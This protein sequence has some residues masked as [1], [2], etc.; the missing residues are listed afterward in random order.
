MADAIHSINSSLDGDDSSALLEQLTN[1]YGGLDNI[2]EHEALQYLK[3][4]RATKAAKVE[5]GI[6]KS[7][8]MKCFYDCFMVAFGRS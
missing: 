6:N 1:H 5:V 2:Q 8:V 7:G 4:L 3:I